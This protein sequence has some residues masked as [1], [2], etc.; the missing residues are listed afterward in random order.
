MNKK[1]LVTGATGFT[2]GYLA[3]ELANRG[4]TVRALSL[5]EQDI[6]KL[7]K[8]G[9]EVVTGDLTKKETLA[10]AVK[11]IDVV[12]HIAAIYREQNVPNHYFFDVNVGGTRNLLESALEAGVKRFVHCSTVGVQG[13]I[14]DPPAK[15]NA[16]YNPGDVYQRSKVEG[17]KLALEFFSENDIEGV[18]FRPVGIFGP[19]DMRFL[20][21]FKW[22]NSGK[23]RMIGNGEVLY[24]LTYVKDLVEGIILCG[25]KKEAVGEVFT[26]GGREYVTLN[27]FVKLLSEVLD[28]PEPK[29][30]IPVWPVWS[31][32]VLCEALCYPL[33]IQPPIYRRRMDFFTKDRAFDISK[34]REMLGYNPSTE[35]KTALKM[36][37]EWYK[38]QK[39]L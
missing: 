5:P 27:E 9:I 7:N 36:T 38:A 3:E 12:Y 19:G 39:M 2:G 32:A 28:V 1:V 29:S 13:E 4:Y 26:L 35:L 22:V 17:E 6:S 10:E 31:A 33:K 18:V 8:L 15:E 11:D 14:K 25:E 21:I 23:F 37:A 20:K 24:H 16:P 34:A 30:R